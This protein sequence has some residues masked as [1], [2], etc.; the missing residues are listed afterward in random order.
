MRS[1]AGGIATLATYLKQARAQDPHTVTVESGDM[2]GASPPESGLLRDK[3]TLDAL[4]L[5]GIDVGTLGNH[6]FDRGVPEMLRQ[7]KGGR[8]RSIPSITFDPLDFPVVDANVIS[9]TT[10]KPLLPPYVVKKVGGV[11]VGFIGA[12]TIT[13]PTIVTT[14]A[15]D[16][17]HFVDEADAINKYVGVLRAPGRARVRRGRPRGRVAVE[18]PGRHGQ[19]PDQRHRLAPRPRRVGGDLRTQPHRDRHPRRVTRW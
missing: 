5:M 10:G 15:T 14:G 18:L 2:V 6:E 8:P 1:P 7:V 19:R 17:V 12:T 11:K 4:N 9:D 13:T 3:P 16:G